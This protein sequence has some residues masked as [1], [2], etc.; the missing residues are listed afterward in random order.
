[1]AKIKKMKCDCRY[2]IFPI[3]SGMPMCMYDIVKE[4]RL[5]EV[6]LQDIPLC[7]VKDC[8]KQKEAKQHDN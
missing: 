6:K 8:P 2:A 5:N 4:H 7:I 3:G 1:M